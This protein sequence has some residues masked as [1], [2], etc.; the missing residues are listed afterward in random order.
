MYSKFLT[1]DL[2]IAR[3]AAAKSIPVYPWLCY[4]GLCSPIVNKYLVY[5]DIDHI[6][7]AYSGFLSQV[8][9]NAVVR[10]VKRH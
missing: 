5:V 7:I 8:V 2:Q 9:T 6:S 10:I 4:G 3:A 1:R